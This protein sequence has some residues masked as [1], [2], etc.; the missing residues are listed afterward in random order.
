MSVLSADGGDIEIRSGRSISAEGLA[1]LVTG[2][3]PQEHEAR[4]VDGC[5]ENARTVTR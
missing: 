2:E 4:P 3:V 5:P 1:F